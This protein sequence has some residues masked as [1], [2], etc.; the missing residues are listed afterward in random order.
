MKI[1]IDIRS[2]LKK[3]T[4][5]GKY[6]ID[7]INALARIDLENT[8]YLYSRKKIFDFKKTLPKLPGVNFSHSIDS[9]KK[10][11][12]KILPDADVFH[13]SSYDLKKPKR[14]KYIV[15]VHD[16]IT[17]A[18]PYG[19]GAKTIKEVNEKLLRVLDEVDILV[20]DSHNTKEDL[21]K[22]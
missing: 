11:P 17:K 12:G 4:G 13:T 7:L 10:G 20:A 14:A 3:T 9:F 6:T 8:Y 16:V 1:G 5:I 2:T 22:Y 19:H 15:T 18:Y 21:M